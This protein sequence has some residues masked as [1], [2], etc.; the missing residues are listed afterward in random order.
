MV[1]VYKL[2]WLE[3]AAYMLAWLVE[4]AYKLAS[5]EVVEVV[6]VLACYIWV[7]PGS[8]LVLA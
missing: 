6:V 2:A 5:F 7:S 3:V 8:S 4:E 1:V